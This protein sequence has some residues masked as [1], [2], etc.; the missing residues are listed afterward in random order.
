MRE[1]EREIGRK[2]SR[3]NTNT[4]MHRSVP[5]RRMQSRIHR[6]NN[7]PCR[8]TDTTVHREALLFRLHAG[9]LHVGQYNYKG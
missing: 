3:Q 4:L 7:T 6:Y 2:L 5:R 9:L 1:R 8:C